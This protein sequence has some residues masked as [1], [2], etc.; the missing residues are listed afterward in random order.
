VTASRVSISQT[1]IPTFP[2][3]T[4]FL[5]KW[6][7]FHQGYRVIHTPDGREDRIAVV[8]E[9]LRDVDPGYLPRTLDELRAGLLAS[10]QLQSSIPEPVNDSPVSTTPQQS[11]EQTLDELLQDA[12]AEE[13]PAPATPLTTTPSVPAR[14]VLPPRVQSILLSDDESALDAQPQA[15]PIPPQS[16]LDAEYAQAEAALFAAQQLRAS[17]RAE[18]ETAAAEED[19]AREQLRR[20]RRRQITAGNFARVFGTREDVQSDEYVSPI[21]SMFTR[22]SQWGRRT[23]GQRQALANFEEI[24]RQT[25]PTAGSSGS[26]LLSTGELMSNW[27]AD[28]RNSLGSLNRSPETAQPETVPS[29]AQRLDA[30]RARQEARAEF[31][32]NYGTPA[33]GETET[34]TP[35]AYVPFNRNWET[36]PEPEQPTSRAT[37]FSNVSRRLSS[38]ASE[39]QADLTRTETN[40]LPSTTDLRRRLTEIEESISDLRNTN[41]SELLPEAHGSLES[42]ERQVRMLHE[43]AQS[44]QLQAERVQEIMEARRASARHAR[45]L[46]LLREA[47]SNLERSTEGESSNSEMSLENQARALFTLSDADQGIARR[48]RTAITTPPER[49][50]AIKGLDGDERPEPKTEEEMAFKLECRICYSQIADT[51]CLPCGHLAMCQWCADQTIPIKDEDRTRPKDKFAKC[52]MCRNRVKQRV[53]IFAC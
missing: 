3:Q 51:A 19:V 20:V 13:N 23:E 29:M 14:P 11:L 24:H 44:V 47:R 16:T 25:Q 18:A 17:R 4:E 53:K 37:T 1:R 12:I 50:S 15:P 46:E 40:G 34:M 6:F 22:V 5:S 8:G 7:E 31:L 35:R 27:R 26:D 48:W 32:R 43:Q 10:E 21:T 36:P 41:H 9:P 42:S 30:L 33:R 2:D 52:P 45:A 38:I 39:F 49:P 28:R